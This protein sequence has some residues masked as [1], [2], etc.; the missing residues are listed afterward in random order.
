M[1]EMAVDFYAKVS[2]KPATKA[3]AQRRVLDAMRTHATHIPA[4][5]AEAAGK[6]VVTEE[7]VLAAM[8]STKP[9]TSPGPDGIPS[10]LWRWCKASTAPLLARLYTAMGALDDAPSGFNKGA[11]SAIYKGKGDA[12]SLSNH[13]PIT[14]LNTDYRLIAKI[15]ATRWGPTLGAAVGREQTA[16]LPGRLIGETVMLLQL[17]PGAL[18]AQRARGLPGTGAAAFLDFQKA[19]DTVD[20]DFLFAAMSAVG[21]G[22]GMRT[23]AQ[24]LLRDT[25]AVAVVNGHVSKPRGWEAGVR[26]GCPLAPAMYLFVAW[27]LACWMQDEQH[28]RWIGQKLGGVRTACSQYADDTTPLLTGWSEQH[29]RALISAMDVFGDASGQRLN[30]AKCQLLPLG[31]TPGDPLPDEIEGMRVVRHATTLGIQFSDE[32]NGQEPAPGVDW[33]QRLKVVRACYDKLA[34]LPLS[35]FG[36]AMGAAAYGVSQL[37]Y[38]AEF[39]DMPETVVE[40]LLKMTT[41]LVDRGLAPAA[42]PLRRGHR[43]PGIRSHLLPGPP[44]SGGVGM[45]PWQEHITARHAVWGRRLAEGLAQLPLA[46][47]PPA[48]SPPWVLAAAEVLRSTAGKTNTHPAF[49]FL[50][51]CGTHTEE[52]QGAAGPQQ[53]GTFAERWDGGQGS[54]PGIECAALRRMVVGLAA[55]GPMATCNLGEVTAGPWVAEMPVWDNPL[56]RLERPLSQRPAAYQGMWQALKPRLGLDAPSNTDLNHA[57]T[58]RE[59]T[60]CGALKLLPECTTLGSL[61]RLHMR[62]DPH[63]GSA[64]WSLQRHGVDRYRM[65]VRPAPQGSTQTGRNDFNNDEWY[66]IQDTATFTF[67][68]RSTVRCLPLRWANAACKAAAHPPTQEQGELAVQTCMRAVGWNVAAVA[69]HPKALCTQAG[70]DAAANEADPLMW[71][72]NSLSVQ[73]HAQLYSWQL[74]LSVKL[75]TRLQQAE[76]Q[77][78]VEAMHVK[79]IRAALRLGAQGDPSEGQVQHQ[80]QALRPRVGKVWR[81][82][83]ENKH[84]ETWCRLLLNGVAGAG[85][86]DI[87]LKG[88]CPCGWAPAANLD[89]AGR[90]AAQRDHVFW[91]CPAA[92]EV[93]KVLT[94]NLPASVQL[95]P[96]HLWLLQPPAPD[97]HWGVWAVVGLSALEAMACARKCMWARHMEKQEEEHEMP[98]QATQRAGRGAGRARKQGTQAQPATPWVAAARKAVT[99]FV[100]GIWDFVDLGTVPKGWGGKVAE[101]HC[102]VRVHST[103]NPQGETMHAL[104]FAVNMPDEDQLV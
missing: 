39:S 29:V 7:E 50:A 9:G 61:M 43:L 98:T 70:R 58:D 4:D 101:G 2:A 31:W 67:L 95:Q 24:L 53:G 36:R 80:L 32:G 42:S 66:L 49:A 88:A 17:L 25:Q 57:V 18:R 41:K 8:K 75:A 13:R 86:H 56:L 20:R 59:E 16:F 96:Y 54:T 104:R 99:R 71:T 85:G 5:L 100:D 90:A 33:E 78:G 34:R 3:E 83:W 40:Q 35:M 84:K 27:A 14:L 26:Q 103:P 74:P 44:A 19:Y 38:H 48:S 23:W 11:V 10:E 93:R 12:A 52:Q 55:A 69:C 21:A 65:A 47:P 60:G 45:M 92:C 91:H 89:S 51:I 46:G 15:M 77:G 63:D 6:A 102:F 81:L 37:L 87:G 68:V 64:C 62:L 79:C 28:A 76:W 1:A 94:H 73:P 97:I 82:P 22:G 30:L 72:P